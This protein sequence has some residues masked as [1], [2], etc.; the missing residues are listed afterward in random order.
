MK[1]YLTSEIAEFEYIISHASSLSSGYGH[2]EI[3]VTVNHEG[4]EKDFKAVTSNMHDYDEA[5][6]LEGQ[7]KY[8]ALFEL[9]E[10][11]IAGQIA[12]WI[13]EQEI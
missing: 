2:R 1:T 7:E 13:Y 11:K 4:Q 12:Q 9:I 6:D 5:S 10:S 8:E 3:F